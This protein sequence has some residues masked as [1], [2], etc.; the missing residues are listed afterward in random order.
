MSGAKHILIADD[1]AALCRVLT[2]HCQHLGL[3][4]HTA[5]DAMHALLLIHKDRPDMVL[6]DIS[7]PAGNGL[8]AC[9]MLA[10]D[11]RL[12]DL[13]IV[14]ISGSSREQ[15]MRRCDELGVRFVQKDGSLWQRLKPMICEQL[16]LRCE[17][18]PVACGK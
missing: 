6:M 15:D 5:H 11:R 18:R 8:S 2:V 14:V 1:D 4:V 13:P 3:H 17:T 12:A 16:G 10:T 7:M 9:E